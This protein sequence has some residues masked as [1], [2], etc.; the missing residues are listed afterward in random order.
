MPIICAR[1]VTVGRSLRHYCRPGRL[2]L[3]D[4]YP[5]AALGKRIEEREEEMMK[6]QPASAAA[7]D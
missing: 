5:P 4:R 3:D 7:D 6:Q 2:H 1:L